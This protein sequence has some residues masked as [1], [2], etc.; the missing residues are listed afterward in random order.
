MPTCTN[1]SALSAVNAGAASAW[2]TLCETSQVLLSLYKHIKASS[3]EE[4]GQALGL[5][6][7]DARSAV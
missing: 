6:G 1:L 7:L 5:F 3:L 2:A 4:S